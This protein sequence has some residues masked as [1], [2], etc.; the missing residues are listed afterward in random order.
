MGRPSVCLSHLLFDQ[1]GQRRRTQN[2]AL[3]LPRPSSAS[4][5][6]TIVL[7]FLDLLG[8]QA[9]WPLLPYLPDVSPSSSYKS[10]DWWTSLTVTCSCGQTFF[11]SWDVKKYSVDWFQSTWENMRLVRKWQ[12]IIIKKE[13]QGA[14]F[15]AN[16]IDKVLLMDWSSSTGCFPFILPNGRTICDAFASRML[17][18][19]RFI[20]FRVYQD[21]AESKISKNSRGGDDFQWTTKH[22]W[23]AAECHG[24]GCNPIFRLNVARY[25]QRQNRSQTTAIAWSRS[26]HLPR[27]KRSTEVHPSEEEIVL[28]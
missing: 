26:K 11:P 9:G 8:H 3:P 22:Q 4:H 25:L 27:N 2:T 21:I 7:A 24:S 23:S 28:G 18:V 5:L 19:N 17:I 14:H 10:F 16:G 12:I 6:Q 15:R 13:K 1:Q 20:S